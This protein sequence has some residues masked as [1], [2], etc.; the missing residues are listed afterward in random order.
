MSK[1][2]RT[3]DPQ[4]PDPGLV[5]KAARLLHRGG[6]LVL[7]TRHLYGL[8][9]DAL[10]PGAAARVFTAKRR[11]WHRPLLILLGSRAELSRYAVGVDVRADLLMDAFWPGKLTIVLPASAVI[12]LVLTGGSG[13]IGIRQTEHPVCRA[14]LKE[15]GRPITATSANIS[16]RP[17]CR[18]IA[19]LDAAVAA[20]VDLILDAGPLEPGI[21][22]TVVDIRPEGVVMLREGAVSRDALN[23]VLGC[24]LTGPLSPTDSAHPSTE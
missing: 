21:G 19:D 2:T 20:E 13:R 14:L 15:L 6:M 16:G 18:R 24:A 5:R 10:N 1:K 9:V 11:P 23:R 17:G 8:G 3:V 4:L 7:P 12:P 22:S